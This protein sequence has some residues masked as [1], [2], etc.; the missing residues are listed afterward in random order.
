MTSDQLAQF[1]SKLEKEKDLLE[2][3]LSRLGTPNP[4]N[5]SDWMPGKPEGEE[6]G[7]DK[8]DNADI[9]EAEGEN[10][11]S[12]NELE[13]RMMLVINALNKIEDG[14]YGV[15]DVGAEEIEL[16]RLTANPAARTCKAHMDKESAM[17]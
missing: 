15:C 12:L 6:F 17:P 1:K 2:E 3:E 14:A 10:N 9:I 5:P 7:A 13:V 4:A 8:N 11:A 16:D